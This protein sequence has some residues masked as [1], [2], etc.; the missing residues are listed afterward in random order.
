L[1]PGEKVMTTSGLKNCEDVTLDD[2]LYSIE[3]K[4]VDIINLQRYYKE[5]EDIYKIKLN[6]IF[7]TT[8]FTKEH[9]IYCS[10]DGKVFDFKRMSQVKEGYFVKVPNIYL[11]EKITN[12]DF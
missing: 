9:P 10:S 11:K 6:N 1:T 2:K 8:T 3:G 5:D 7:R 4:P 12:F